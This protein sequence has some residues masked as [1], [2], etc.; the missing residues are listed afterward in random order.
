MRI[1]TEHGS[2]LV[3]DIVW[4]HADAVADGEITEVEGIERLRAI[5]PNMERHNP[6]GW[7]WILEQVTEP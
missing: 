3:E 5:F 2:A 7:Q 6:D 4:D 1:K